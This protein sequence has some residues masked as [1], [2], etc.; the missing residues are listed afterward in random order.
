MVKTNRYRSTMKGLTAVFL[1]NIIIK[2]SIGLIVYPDDIKRIGNLTNKLE[3]QA[4]FTNKSIQSHFTDL[5]FDKI[6]TEHVDPK[7]GYAKYV[8]IQNGCNDTY[9]YYEIDKAYHCPTIGNVIAYEQ[10]NSL[11]GVYYILEGCS[12]ID[13]FPVQEYTWILTDRD[14]VNLYD[15]KIANSSKRFIFENPISCM[16]GGVYEVLFG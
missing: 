12:A 9:L 2:T 4:K 13:L 3:A 16:H 15:L 1:Y 14:E 11:D 7:H 10:V 5:N 8:V 6:V